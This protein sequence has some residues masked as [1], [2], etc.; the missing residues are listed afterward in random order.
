MKRILPLALL[1]LT[2]PLFAQSSLT[3]FA[4][5]Q[6]NGGSSRFPSDELDL[7]VSFDDGSGFGAAYARAF[8][9]RFSGE[10]AVFSTTSDARVRDTGGDSLVVGDIDLTPITAMLRIHLRRDGPFDAYAGAGA[11]YVM[12]GDVVTDEPGRVPI[13]DQLTLAVGAGASWDF[14]RRV[15]LV[16]DARYLPLT[17]HGR[18]DGEDIDADMDPL[19]LSAGVRFRF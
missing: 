14:T 8:G 10:L 6:H 17:L 7:T 19:L 16:V 13:D 4:T 12:T 2:T 9:S 18:S 15:G 1:L 5:S 3:F 11:A